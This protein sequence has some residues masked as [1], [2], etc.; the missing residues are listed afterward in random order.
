MWPYDRR[1]G[2]WR[3]SMTDLT[4]IAEWLVLRGNSMI[5]IHLYRDTTGPSMLM[6]VLQSLDAKE[7]LIIE[8]LRRH[9]NRDWNSE[10]R[11]AST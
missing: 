7:H 2:V 9:L 5:I 3:V 8:H 1:F 6:N 4:W 11:N 10:L